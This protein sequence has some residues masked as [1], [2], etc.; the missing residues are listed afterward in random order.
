MM[1]DVKIIIENAINVFLISPMKKKNLLIKFSV[2]LLAFLR[3][4]KI[5]L[6]F[7]IF[8]VCDSDGQIVVVVVAIRKKSTKEISKDP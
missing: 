2:I 6:N 4:F 8:N 3:F 1:F 5:P 7:S